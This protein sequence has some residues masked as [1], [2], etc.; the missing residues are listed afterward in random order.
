[1]RQTKKM[2]SLWLYQRSKRMK[3]C[4]LRIKMKKRRKRRS[5][6]SLTLLLAIP[7]YPKQ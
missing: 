1:M 6:S 7:Q 2:N 5:R 4:P 3:M